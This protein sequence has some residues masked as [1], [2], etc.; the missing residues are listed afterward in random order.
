MQ[1]NFKD[2]EGLISITVMHLKAP[3]L[4]SPMLRM[5][6]RE[7]SQLSESSVRVHLMDVV[8]SPRL[9]RQDKPLREGTVL[10]RDTEEVNPSI[11]DLGNS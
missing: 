4:V 2:A 3:C 7:Q 6:P 11:A 1:T 5:F 9:Q 8:I 10:F